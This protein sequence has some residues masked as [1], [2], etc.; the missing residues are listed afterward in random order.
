VSAARTVAAPVQV[1]RPQAAGVSLAPG[2]HLAV[3]LIP[4]GGA[5]KAHPAIFVIQGKDGVKPAVI[6]T[7]KAPSTGG[8]PALPQAGGAGS[9]TGA[10]AATA[11]PAAPVAATAFPFKLPDKPGP[12][13]SQA[14]ATNS[15]DGG[16]KYSVVYSLVTV[17]GGDTVDEENS[18]YA[19]ASCK[20][21]TTVA[22]SFQLVLIVGQSDR[23]MPINVAEALNVN[24]PSCIT[25]AIADQIVV[26]VRSVPSDELVR[27]LTA[28]LQKLGAIEQLGAGGSP[29]DVA[30]AVA[31]VQHDIEQELKD[32]GL[33]VPAATPTATPTA[34]AT[35]TPRASP[36]A[37]PTATAQAGET[38]TATPTAT[39]T[40]TDTPAPTPTA[41]A[42]A[43]DAT[44]T[45]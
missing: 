2:K 11:A 42:T 5:T 3:A 14:L 15:T 43:A 34:T 22:V 35:A 30:A 10:P 27:A 38:A 31:G 7:D 36:T 4:A 18:A 23:I 28:E 13:D 39:P 29:A 40:A 16:V 8:T 20:A 41:T 32:S 9:S 1:A 26:T 19:L 44:P 24:C 45:P 37:S 25:T 12:H 17:Q 6:V 33:L 21:C